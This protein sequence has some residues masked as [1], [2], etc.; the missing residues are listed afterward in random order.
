MYFGFQQAANKIFEVVNSHPWRTGRCWPQHPALTTAKP[1]MTGDSPFPR[2]RENVG[3]E[4]SPFSS[5]RWFSTRRDSPPPTL[6]DKCLETFLV[7]PVNP[8]VKRQ[9]SLV[10][11]TDPQ[12]K[13]STVPR[14]RDPAVVT[15]LSLVSNTHSQSRTNHN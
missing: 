12:H 4:E 14:G 11:G 10:H 9:K 2:A 7:V 5:V 6:G 1:L 15:K 13:T 8:G 3:D